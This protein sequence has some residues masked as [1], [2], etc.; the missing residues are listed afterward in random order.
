MN[1]RNNRDQPAVLALAIAGGGTV[2]AWAR[3]HEGPERTADTWAR[4]PEVRKQVLHI[5]RR[6]INRAVGRLSR[7]ASAATDQ[8]IRLARGAESESV[9]LQAAR[10]VLADLMTVSNDAALEERIAEVEWRIA[11]ARPAVTRGLGPAPGRPAGAPPPLPAR[12]TAPRLAERCRVHVR[13]TGP[14]RMPD[15][16]IDTIDTIGS[17]ELRKLAVRRRFGAQGRP[18][19]PVATAPH[20]GIPAFSS[21]R[22]AEAPT[23]V[24]PHSG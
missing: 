15:G 23:R 5:R 12:P 13:A 21:T 4:S 7:N 16:M 19:G 10:A 14:D 11:Q 3:A 6:A 24:P 17:G 22:E 20:R 9:Q 1:L 18:T 8:I 2:I